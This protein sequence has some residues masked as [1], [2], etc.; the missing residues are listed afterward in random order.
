MSTGQFLSVA[1]GTRPREGS[2][3]LSQTGPR[4][5]PVSQPLSPCPAHT[6]PAHTQLRGW[7]LAYTWEYRKLTSLGGGSSPS[8]LPTECLLS[9]WPSMQHSDKSSLASLGP[10]G[11]L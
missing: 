1:A 10:R 7:L 9:S 3:P 11:Q 6:L 4:F 8:F 5:L 2:E